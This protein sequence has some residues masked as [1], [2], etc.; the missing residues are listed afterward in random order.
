MKI[1]KVSGFIVLVLGLMVCQ[2]SVSEAAPMGTAWTYQGR[3]MDAN[4]PADGQYDFEF[5][6]FADPVLNS[7]QIGGTIDINDLDVIDGY[8]TVLL[9]FGNN[10]FT[11][12]ARWLEIGV[13]PGDS[14]ERVTILDPRQEVTP[15]PYAIYAENTDNDNDW[16]VINNNMY[17]IPTGYI[18]IGTNEPISKLEVVSTESHHGIRSTVPYIAVYGH[19][20]GVTGTWPGVHGQCD[21]NSSNTSGVRGVITST[22]PGTN[23]AGVRGTN[24]GTGD[25]GAGVYGWHAGDGYGVYGDTGDN[26]IGVYGIHSSSTGKSPGVKG[27]TNTTSSYCSAILGEA[28]STTGTVYGVRGVSASNSGMGVVGR[29]TAASGETTGVYGQSDSIGGRGVVGW[30]SNGSGANYGGYFQVASADGTGVYA[31]HDSGSGTAP[32]VM[33]RND[34]GSNYAYSV[35]GKLNNTSAGSMS[36]GVRGENIGTGSGGI[37]VWG[38]H[39]GTGWGVYGMCPAGTGVRAWGGYYGV[40][41]VGSIFTTGTYDSSSDARFKEDVE[42]LTDSLNKV[43]KLRGVEFSWKQ[44]EYPEHNFS[45]EKQ[46]GFIAQEVAEVLPEVVNKSNDEEGFYSVSYG[47]IVPVLVEAIKELKAE[48][49]LLKDQLKAQNKSLKERLE[50]LERRID[51]RQFAITKEVR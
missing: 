1:T 16:M 32:A 12:D 31:F 14:E 51:E 17:S 10:A 6:L 45:K 43:L 36:A 37:G 9:D 39:S 21:S 22:T 35:H 15:T 34:S 30:A 49:D 48:N 47:R 24:N 46:V 4:G 20:T 50:V 3:L 18:G 26:G 7:F 38:S 13:R 33:A 19:R 29:A 28:T 2:V 25:K 44:D 5:R 42:P 11:G 40:Y 41:S 23:S 27:V 8:F